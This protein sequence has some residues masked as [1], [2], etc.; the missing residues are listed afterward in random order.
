MRF[1]KPLSSLLEFMLASSDV[2]F[3][4]A[5]SGGGQTGESGADE[6][7]VQVGLA[8]AVPL[9]VCVLFFSHL[10]ALS[11]SLSLSLSC[12]LSRS[13]YA[14]LYFFLPP[15]VFPRLCCE[16]FSCPHLFILA[17][18]LYLRLRFRLSP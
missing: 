9:L 14:C 5:P 10:L 13:L 12:S 6:S 16:S 4:E 18:C 8:L 2:C 11:F 3:K 1:L 17:Y 15:I 7:C